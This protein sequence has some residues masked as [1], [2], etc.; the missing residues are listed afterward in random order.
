MSSTRRGAE[1]RGESSLARQRR[2]VLSDGGRAGPAFLQISGSVADLLFAGPIPLTASLIQIN[3]SVPEGTLPGD[4]AQ[5]VLMSAGVDTLP[6]R[7]SVRQT[8]LSRRVP[9]IM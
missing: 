6:I 2:R 8:E 4:T 3:A 9:D 1:L 7:F 5:T